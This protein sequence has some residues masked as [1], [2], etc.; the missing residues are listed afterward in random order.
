MSEQR[1]RKIKY[2]LLF[3][4]FLAIYVVANHYVKSTSGSQGVTVFFGTAIP[5]ASFTGV[6]SALAN[7]SIILMVVNL[8][9]PGFLAALI[10]QLLQFPG[11][12]MGMITGHSFRGLPGV[13]SGVMLIITIIIIRRRNVRIEEYRE[14]EMEKLQSEKK[15]AKRL[16]EQTATALVNA[17]DA[18]DVY[19][20][21]HSLRVAEYSRK[22]AQEMGKGEE[23]CE[24]IYYA[25]LLHDVGKIGIADNI[26]TKNGK[27]TDEEYETIK[28]H[29]KMGKQILDGISEFPYISVGA[30]FHHERYD[31][32]GYPE[33]LK[34]EEIPEVARIIS[35]A[36]SYDTMTSNRSYREAMPQQIVR[37]EIVK[38]AGTQFDPEIAKIMQH[39]IDIDGEYEMKESEEK[40]VLIDE[41]EI[42]CTDYK[43]AV[44]ESIR[45]TSSLVSIHL[46]AEP[47]GSGEKGVPSI[48]L[49]DSLDGKYHDENKVPKYLS[50]LEFAEIRLDGEVKC[51][52]A[53][54]TEVNVRELVGD[55]KNGSSESYEIE[56][57]KYKDHIKVRITGGLKEVNVI[58]ALNDSTRFVYIGLT[59][60]HCLINNVR[61]KRS[62]DTV[63][64]NYIKRIAPEISYIDGPEGDL[65]NIQV[66]G[67]RTASTAGIPI[68]DG[69]KI[70]FHS[71]TLPNAGLIWHCPYI[72]LC[73]SKEGENA[74][75][76]REYS[77]IR[78]DG[79][80]WQ[81]PQSVKN[82]MVVERKDEFPGWDE[83]KIKNKQGFDCMVSFERK[84]DRIIM[85]TENFGIKIVSTTYLKNSDEAFAILT[86]DQ[87]ALTNIRISK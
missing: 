78:I 85:S 5:I 12:I 41:T 40:K 20:H 36:D 75:N 57:V 21:G 13:F 39:L 62:E 58:A 30:H 87:C 79:E 44:S 27:L 37:E 31:G 48:V 22:I 35:V 53:R 54:K 14:R 8:G 76:Y 72:A 11:I 68:K 23:D 46:D 59:G 64:E 1:I 25:A 26:L 29:S 82:E 55:G 84:N 3:I 18:K 38:G 83:W 67:Y 74:E 34:G 86:G 17:I 56:A 65:P 28:Q 4:I 69:M 47:D 16:F 52:G 42:L 70:I 50:Y 43:S 10:I 9:K 2:I 45:V 15:L 71:M 80:S 51:K 81:T 33:G 32:K 63:N 24:K 49:F 73:N 7:M 60:E 66:D 19:S 61:L 6:F 77:F